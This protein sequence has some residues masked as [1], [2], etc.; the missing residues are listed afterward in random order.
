M[1]DTIN[2]AT[3]GAGPDVLDSSEDFCSSSLIRAANIRRE[4]FSSQVGRNRAD[5]TGRDHLIAL[6]LDGEECIR[7]VRW[8]RRI[9]R[10]GGNSRSSP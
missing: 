5:T 6:E 1:A 2:S 9:L 3:R 8:R 4:Q 10:R 7:A